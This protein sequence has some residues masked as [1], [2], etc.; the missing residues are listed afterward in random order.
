MDKITKE[1]RS[2]TMS[3]VHSKDTKPEL[4]VRKKLWKLGLRYK[5]CDPR[6]P[7]KPDIFFPKYHC[8]VFVHGCFWHRHSDCKHAT[9]PQNNY[10]YWQKKFMSNINRDLKVRNEL[11]N[12]GIRVIVVWECSVNKLVKGNDSLFVKQLYTEIIQGNSNYKEY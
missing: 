12:N 4:I 11:N 3:R 1:Q 5:V 8:A 7:G 6:I 2:Q 10:E 9:T